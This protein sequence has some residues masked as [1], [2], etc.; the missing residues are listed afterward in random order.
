MLPPFTPAGPN[1]RTFST[2]PCCAAQV[3]TLL[4]PVRP[5]VLAMFKSRFLIRNPA[6]EIENISAV[7]EVLF[8][9]V[10]EIP[11][12]SMTVPA[13]PAPQLNPGEPLN[14]IVTLFPKYKYIGTVVVMVAAAD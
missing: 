6:Q 7:D 13:A 10:V 2:T 11:P 1:T 9:V 5:T 12:P 14:V 4:A 3:M 8:I